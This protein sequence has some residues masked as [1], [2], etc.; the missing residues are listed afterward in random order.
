MRSLLKYRKHLMKK[1]QSF[2]KI[3]ENRGRGN[4]FC[5]ILLSQYYHDTSAKTRHHKK[6][7]NYRYP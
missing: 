6:N 7:K 3:R 5:I 1:N 2:K 4:I